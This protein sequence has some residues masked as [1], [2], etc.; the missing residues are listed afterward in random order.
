MSVPLDERWLSSQ[1]ERP[2][3]RYTLEVSVT[4]GDDFEWFVW[5][6]R[7]IAARGTK[8]DEKAAK[9]AARRWAERNPT[10]LLARAA[11]VRGGR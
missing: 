4:T 9:L 2:F 6:G 7:L 1:W 10:G 3:G 8:P 5:L 11:V